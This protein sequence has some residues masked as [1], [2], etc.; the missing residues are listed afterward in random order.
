MTIN[1]YSTKGP[2][3]CFSNFS[4]HPVVFDGFKW[5]TS[6]VMVVTAQAEICSENCSW[7]SENNSATSV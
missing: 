6:G 3:E 1:F 5:P 4:R 2:Y 7:K